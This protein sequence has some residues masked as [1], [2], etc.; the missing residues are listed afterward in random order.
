MAVQGQASNEHVRAKEDMAQSQ[1]YDD[2]RAQAG[3]DL[4]FKQASG[5]DGTAMDLSNF[6]RSQMSGGGQNPNLENLINTENTLG[7]KSLQDNM[8]LIRSGG[9][10]GGAG[11]GAIDQGMFLSDFTSRRAAD[12]ARLRY[13]DYNQGVTN[14][15]QGA[16]GLT[17]VA[18]QNTN[19]ANSLLNALRGMKQNKTGV[20]NTQTVSAG[21]AGVV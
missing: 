17:G 7:Q 16:A 12:N 4:L 3:L 9:Y 21:G 10:R 1:T 14:R 13:D 19:A 18:G 6:F 11:R 5:E 15:F 20:T 2:P 8:A